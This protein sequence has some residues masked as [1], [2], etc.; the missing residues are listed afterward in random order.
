MTP[1]QLENSKAIPVLSNSDEDAKSCFECGIPFGFTKPNM[2]YSHGLTNKYGVCSDCL[3]KEREWNCTSCG[4]KRFL[5]LGFSRPSCK[6]CNLKLTPSLVAEE[7]R[8]KA[9]SKE[10]EQIKKAETM[11]KIKSITVTTSGNIE[12]KKTVAYLGII[13]G[14]VVASGHNAT[15]NIHSNSMLGHAVESIAEDIG[16]IFMQKFINDAIKDAENLLK[17]SALNLGA[18]AVISVSINFVGT[19]KTQVIMTGTAIFVE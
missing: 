1:V 7:K 13:H 12:G 9:L 18:N 6:K 11:E 16:A 15:E 4:E 5:R 2:A 3:F 17:I 10:D 19:A 14:S 8:I